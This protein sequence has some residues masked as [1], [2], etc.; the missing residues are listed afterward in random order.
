VLTQDILD[1]FDSQKMYAVYDQWPSI[2]NDTYNLKFEKI[3][4]NDIDHIV[5]AGMGGSGTIGDIFSAIFSKTNIHLDVVKGYT[6]PKTVSK[7]SLVITTSVSGNTKETLSILESA[8]KIDCQLIAFSSGGKMEDF[9]RKNKIIYRK[10]PFYHS[11]RASLTTFLYSMINIL[12]SL[13]PLSKNDIIDSITQLE[14]LQKQISS[15]NLTSNNPAISLA[16]CI[17]SSPVVYYPFGLE[18]AAIR[19]KNSLQENAKIQAL[20]EDVIEASHNSIVCWDFPSN[21]LPIIIEGEDDYIKTK[22]RWIILKEF[23]NSKQI[24]FNEI[25]SIHG[26]ILSK[27]VHL[28]YLFDYTSIYRAVLSETDPSPV[29]PIDFI[30]SKLT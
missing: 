23:F 3:N 29:E 30:K 24:K 18:S 22:E 25:K 9:C 13:L 15:K 28:I 10:I 4:F 27:L 26:N 19:F 21:L 8:S 20:T 12:E 6:L 16:K 1:K 14:I 11:P 17:S 2:S 5:F 7:N